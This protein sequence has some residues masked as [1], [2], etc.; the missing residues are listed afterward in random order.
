MTR[1]SCA[2]AWLASA[3][4][5]AILAPLLAVGMAFCA[6][7]AADALWPDKEEPVVEATD[8]IG[9][10]LRARDRAR[11]RCD[12]CGVIEAIR[13]SDG[14]DGSPVGFAFAVRMPDGSM[15]HSTDPLPG[16]WQVGDR[17][18]LIGGPGPAAP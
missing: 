17:V 13:R 12:S 16:R 10:A 3:G 1:L 7:A 2:T 15:R 9:N 14:G 11:L 6:M 5:P 8:T 18:L 4:V